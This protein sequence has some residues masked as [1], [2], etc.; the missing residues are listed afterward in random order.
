MVIA[1]KDLPGLNHLSCKRFMGRRWH[2]LVQSG[3]HR[4]NHCKMESQIAGAGD[5][6]L[7]TSCSEACLGQAWLDSLWDCAP[8]QALIYVVTIGVTSSSL[9]PLMFPAVHLSCL[10]NYII[11]A[12]FT[13]LQAFPMIAF[14]LMSKH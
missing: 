7:L 5:P 8:R 11:S 6:F 12:G 9:H 1:F 10:H 2:Y 14:L 3:T 4:A 13:L